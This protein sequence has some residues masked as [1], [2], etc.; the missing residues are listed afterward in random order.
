MRMQ[1]LHTFSY[2]RSLRKHPQFA[3]EKRTSRR[4]PDPNVAITATRNKKVRGGIVVQTEDPLGVA[5]EQFMS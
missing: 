2:R 3:S 1:C 4:A 5:F